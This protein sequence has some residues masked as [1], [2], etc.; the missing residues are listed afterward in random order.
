MAPVSKPPKPPVA[1]RYHHGDLRRALLEGAAKAPDIEQVSLRELALGLGV[2]AAAVYRHFESREALLAE[3][4]ALG[5][6]QLQQR[7]AEAFDL[8]VPAAD[9]RDAI[10]RLDRLTVAYLRF[11]DEEPA[12]WRL[13]FG[14]HAERARAE[15]LQRG[16]PTAYSYLPAM[17]QGL[18]TTGVTAAPPALGDILF[19]WSTV[20][21]A[22]ALRVGNVA[23][24][25]GEVEQVGT[26]LARRILRGLGGKPMPA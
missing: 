3:L 22:A 14:V 12:M 5:I 18:H 8:H 26:E 24:A 6:G 13:I 4:A 19:T 17:L 9:A 15:A 21:G 20:Q 23:P 11:A 7:F 16:T 10:A 1:G 25:Q 2:S